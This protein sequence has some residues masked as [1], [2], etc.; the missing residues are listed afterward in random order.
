MEGSH[1]TQQFQGT[2]PLQINAL[3]RSMCIVFQ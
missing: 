2:D 1:G 3:L